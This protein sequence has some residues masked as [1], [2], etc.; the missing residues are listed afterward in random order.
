MTRPPR[1]A[2]LVLAL[3]IA[4]CSAPE[5]SPANTSAVPALSAPAADNRPKV[6]VI[7]EENKGYDQII[8]A[9]DAPYLNQLAT[10]YGTATNMDAGYPPACPSLASYIL[11][12]SGTTDGICDDKAPKA[13][14]LSGDNLFHQVATA[15]REWRAYAEGA[16]RACARQNQDRYLVRHVPA[17]YYL[18]ERANC[19]R[20][21]VPLDPALPR[22][23]AA[24]TLPAF[25]FVTPD[26]CND[27]H[28][29]TG[30]TDGLVAIGD[31]WL[32]AWLP[33][34]LAGA[35]YR[36]GR[37]LVVVTFDEGTSTDNHIP[38]IVIAPTIHQVS[39]G[40]PFTHCATL[41]M[42]EDWLSLPPLGC[43]ASAASMTTAFGL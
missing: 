37:L 19:A 21:A 35:D 14:Q 16:P 34:I 27:M 31:R 28:G 32:K 30:C 7:E 23:L 42:M 39:A 6:L 41:R 12:T 38:T 26:A 9:P 33:R 15:G 5:P 4:G 8:G 24:G 43:A 40:Q 11:M 22:D 20:W 10:T 3:T 18:D 13:H 25:S 36:A 17:T 2:A 1:L 29:A